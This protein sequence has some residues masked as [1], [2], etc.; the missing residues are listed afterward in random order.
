MYLRKEVLNIYFSFVLLII[1]E[2]LVNLKLVENMSGSL[3]AM[4]AIYGFPISEWP[5]LY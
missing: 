5:L 3:L 2:Q 1:K 4:Y